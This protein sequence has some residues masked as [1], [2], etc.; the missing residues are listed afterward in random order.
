MLSRFSPQLWVKQYNFK[1]TST[2]VDLCASRFQYGNSAY[3]FVSM[4]DNSIHC[5]HLD[6]LIKAVSVRF[7][8]R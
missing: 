3:L 4:T 5:L 8:Y 1:H 6:T 7:A 2:I